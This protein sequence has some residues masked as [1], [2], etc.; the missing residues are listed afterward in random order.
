M[1][2]PAS[3]C[4]VF[5]AQP[6][7]LEFI[8]EANRRLALETESRELDVATL[9]AGVAAALA[10]ER[11]GRYFV[12]EVDGRPVGTLMLTSEWS[13]WRNG[14]FWWF[15]SVYVWP[16]SRGAGVFRALYSHVLE[17][18]RSAPGICGLRLYV[19]HHNAAARETYLH[20]GMK[21]AGY[22]VFEVDFS[23]VAR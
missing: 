21:D 5:P 14:E 1:S 11:R 15:Q 20:L 6:A 12:A 22:T 18:A 19:D 3:H 4:S 17:A 16:E 2:T 23:A 9:T 10:D 13:D 7:H 8:V